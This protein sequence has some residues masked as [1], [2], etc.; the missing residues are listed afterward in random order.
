[1]LPVRNLA[2]LWARLILTGLMVA[3]C[4][5]QK[6][7]VR[8]T[9]G[10]LLAGSIAVESEAD[11]AFA[12]VA[13]PA[14]LKMMET[15]L[16]VDPEN[17]DLLLLLTKGYSSYALLFIEDAM[18]VA[19]LADRLEEEEALGARGRELY[20][21]ARAFAYRLLD[22]PGF[23]GRTTG[24]LKSF[25]E[26]LAE[27]DKEQ[28][29]PL[30]WLAYAWGGYVNLG[31]HDPDVVADLPMVKAAMERVAALDERYFFA[32]PH[33][34]LG[35]INASL[36][37]MLG[38]DPARA[39]AHFD[40]ALGFTEGKFLLV[41][42]MAA[43]HHAVQTQDAARFRSLMGQ[44]LDTPADVR[45][46]ATLANAVAKRRAR[47]WLDHIDLLFEDPGTPVAP[48]STDDEGEG[49]DDSTSDF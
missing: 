45:R 2:R 32:G 29:G 31:R 47:R 37:P 11:P 21:R 36:P 42:Y 34:A 19:Q 18:E 46:G 44:V 15:F 23:E 48:A 8:Q 7:A 20:L 41:Q 17:E 1:M 13:L 26:A 4:S 27:I 14:N 16:E 9:A 12:E 24:S 25:E 35:V 43:R 5:M 10:V 28:A 38:G 3:G 30:F 40:K 39:K 33:L 22:Q 6:L 49:I